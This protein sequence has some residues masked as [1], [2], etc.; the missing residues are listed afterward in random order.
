MQITP[1]YLTWTSRK[2][3]ISKKQIPNKIQTANHNKQNNS[4]YQVSMSLFDAEPSASE[5]GH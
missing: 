1:W 2:F 4:C 5:I 3:Q